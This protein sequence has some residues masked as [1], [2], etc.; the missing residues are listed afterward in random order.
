MTLIILICHLHACDRIAQRVESCINS[1]MQ[2]QVI[3]A[4]TDRYKEGDELQISCVPTVVA[5]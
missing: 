3:L 5:H 1:A 2:A 4:Q